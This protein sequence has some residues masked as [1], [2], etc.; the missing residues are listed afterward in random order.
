MD[1]GPYLE[2]A[3]EEVVVKVVLGCTVRNGLV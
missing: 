3:L 2:M 1:F